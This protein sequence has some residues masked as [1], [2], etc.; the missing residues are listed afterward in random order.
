MCGI[1]GV[2]DTSGVDAALLDPMLDCITHRGPD[3]AGR[4]VESDGALAMG[5]RRLSIVDLAGGSQPIYNE[6]GTVAVVF[7]GEIYNHESVRSA[8]ERAGHEFTTA[9]DTEV[10]VHG[11]EEYGRRLPEHLDGMF[12]FAIWDADARRFFLARDRFGIKPLYYAHGED[13]AGGSRLVWGS[14]LPAVLA[15]G[16]GTGI[17]RRAVYNFF[18][19]RYS[20]GPRTLVSGVRK[21]PPGTSMTV[22]PDGGV[23]RR[24]YWQ[25]PA[26]QR[27]I[28]FDA[29]A[30]RVSE[31]LER[32]VERRLMA[33]VPVG[34]FLSGG[35]DSS[36]IAALA[37]KH[38]DETLKTFSIGFPGQP[39]D[40]SDEA[41]F[42]ADSL[43]TDHHRHAVDLDSMELF[44]DLVTHYGEPLADPAALPTMLLSRVA[45]DQVKVVLTGEGADELF[46][47]YRRH[48]LLP[49]GRR[50]ARHLPAAV[51]RAAG[52]MA[53]R[54]P[55]ER[56]GVRRYARFVA[57]LES[58]ET[59]VLDADR[60]YSDIRPD[61]YLDTWTDPRD[62]GLVDLVRDSF[63]HAEDETL[64]RLCA[65]DIT[66]WLPD[67]LLYKVDH[68]SMA[69]S[70][71]ARVP[72][73]DHRLV[74]FAHSVPGDLKTGGY[75]RLL[76]AA[77]ADVV[78]ER[79]RQRLKHGF[80][81]PVSD[82]FR[83]DHEAISGWLSPDRVESTPYLD[84]GELSALRTAHR[85]GAADH[86]MTLWK[87]LTYVAWY[88]QHG[89]V[90]TA[91]AD[92]P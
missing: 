72:F 42:V 65:F 51:F 27:E 78:P 26:R 53:D 64:Q 60:G 39:Q 76:N 1:A 31:L 80:N 67:D 66:R 90:A 69:A 47:G 62:S 88:H 49:R 92:P 59:A 21:L 17:D 73:L 5:M 30:E 45:R 15:A 84:A 2:Y 70:L 77:V 14:E 20:P 44:G 19:L 3:E 25:L 4:H 24:Q 71:E 12:A 48:R 58:D 83:R 79:T 74:A 29:A 56:A 40:E 89:H 37:A 7:N 55:D 6:D 9:S 32:A 85:D 10:L 22:G 23:D 46:A 68:A 18:S 35:L 16:A 86:G 38:H 41:A 13:G 33:D 91:S 63:E 34:A 54:L 75:K 50:M 87:C 43:G 61:R 36:A 11:W 8:L 52:E 57:S 28:G 81:V 82:W